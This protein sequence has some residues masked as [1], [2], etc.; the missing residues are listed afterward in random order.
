M[1]VFFYD[2]TFEGLLTAVFDAYSRKVF[3]DKL[4]AEGAIAPMF[5][6]DSY[7]VVTQEDRATRVWKALDSKFTKGALN[8]LTYVWL[9]EEE[10]SD[11]LLFR[12]IRKAIDSKIPIETNFAD[13]DVLAMSQLARKVSHEEL[14]LKQFVRFQKAADDIFF[15]PVSPRYNALP[16]AIGHFKDR[17]SDQKW[18]IY[19]IK[20]RYGYYYDLNTMVEMTLDNDEHLLGGKLDESLMAEDEKIFQELWKGYFKS[21]TI[22]ERINPKLQRQ[23]MPRR[24]WKYLTEKQ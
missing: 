16:L 4:L 3:P 9:S 7:T 18:V 22:K 13:S 24:F 2:K 17:F 14:Y 10:G 11:D 8:M 21:M 15:A 5:M 19:D 1:I 6:E 20:R 12:Y 23:H